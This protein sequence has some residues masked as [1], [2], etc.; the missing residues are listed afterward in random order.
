[1]G[2]DSVAGVPV[3]SSAG[4]AMWPSHHR[5][6]ARRHRAAERA[7]A[8][9]RRAAGGPRSTVDE[10]HVAVERGVAVAGEMLG[11]GQ[12]AAFARAAH[13]GRDQAA[14]HL[15]VLAVGADV[16]HGVAGVVVDVDHRRER[17]V[18]AQRAPL[19]RGHHAREVR[20]L[21][22]AR[23]PDRHRVRDGDDTAADAEGHPA[24]HVRGDEQGH[25]GG[26]LQLVQQRGQRLDLG[27]EDHHAADAAA[28]GP[29]R[30]ARAARRRAG[31]GTAR[32]RARRSSARPCRRGSSGPASCGPRGRAWPGA[33]AG[34]GPPRP[35]SRRD[36][37]AAGNQPAATVAARSPAAASGFN[38]FA[39]LPTA[40]CASVRCGSPKASLRRRSRSAW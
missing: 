36:V 9:R 33:P 11:R 10:L 31:C 17:P 39:I 21:L 25:G 29:G 19:A 28:A 40:R 35:R 8:P 23:G 26:V 4:T 20:G 5:V 7:A 16:D 32:R 38:V 1:M 27:L 22:R 14:H 18:D 37:A 3:A 30:A 13:E 6:H 24:L 34:T 15:R 12:Q 2:A